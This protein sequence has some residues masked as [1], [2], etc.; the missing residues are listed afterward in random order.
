MKK[1][2]IAIL[3]ALLPAVALAAGGIIVLLLGVY[4]MPV[5]DLMKVTL[6]N[7]IEVVG[8]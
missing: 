2:L 8:G 7:L 6:N 5:L 1:P 3:F 4:P